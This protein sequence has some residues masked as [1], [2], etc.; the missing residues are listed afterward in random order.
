MADTTT[1][2][3]SNHTIL[4]YIDF[5]EP[6]ISRNNVSDW[7]QQLLIYNHTTLSASSQLYI[8]SASYFFRASKKVGRWNDLPAT[9]YVYIGNDRLIFCV[10][11][12]CCHPIHIHD[13]NNTQHWPGWWQPCIDRSGLYRSSDDGGRRIIDSRWKHAYKT[14]DDRQKVASLIILYEQ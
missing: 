3:T 8:L 13:A 14:I 12:S 1:P 5:M 6:Q 9:C 2:R 4:C 7:Y 11:V 10:V